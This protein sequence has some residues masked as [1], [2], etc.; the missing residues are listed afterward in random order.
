MRMTDSEWEQY[1]RER[2]RQKV[3]EQALDQVQEFYH[4][5]RRRLSAMPKGMACAGCPY[6]DD[7]RF[8]CVIGSCDAPYID[9]DWQKIDREEKEAISF[10]REMLKAKDC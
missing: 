1:V 4:Y 10:V 2:A 5:K 9:I 8:Q 3:I 6:W 7:M